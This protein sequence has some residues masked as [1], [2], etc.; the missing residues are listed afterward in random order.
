LFIGYLS[1][2]SIRSNVWCIIGFVEPTDIISKRAGELKAKKMHS[3]P[4]MLQ[5]L[6]HP[7]LEGFPHDECC[8][9]S[10]LS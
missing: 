8:C 2:E 6:I 10:A 5:C 9:G 4:R 3:L 7:I 1:E